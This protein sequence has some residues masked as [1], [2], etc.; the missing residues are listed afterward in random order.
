MK[1]PAGSEAGTAP[2]ASFLSPFLVL[3]GT[4]ALKDELFLVSSPFYS[5]LI[6]VSF[7]F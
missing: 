7:F 1:L 5:T 4:A 2:V 6:L 3:S